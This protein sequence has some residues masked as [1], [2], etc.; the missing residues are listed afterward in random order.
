MLHIAICD[1]EPVEIRYLTA[2]VTQWAAVRGYTLRVSD[3]N[4]AEDFLFAYEDN[5]AMDILLLDIQMKAM[6][7]VA[8]A[9]RLRQLGNP[10]Q[11][12]FITGMP[13][14][15]AEGYDVSALHYLLKPVK[16][17]RLFGVLDKAVTLMHKADRTILLPRGGGQVR[18][19]AEDIW[20][21][22]VLSH[23]VSLCMT[24]GTA[25]TFPMRLSDMEA[26]LGEGFFKCHRSFIV[27]MAHVQRVTRT[28]MVLTGGKN[29]TYKD[30]PLSRGL[31][32][33]ANQ[34]FIHYN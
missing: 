1:D 34:A 20:Y 15:M 4:S 29:Q 25:Q 13:D 5:A 16:E 6:D 30:I 23:T 8:L 3:F 9:R 26:L 32:D 7:G 24:N 14:Y 21:A 10:A 22:E 19:K 12:V 28:A 2:L 18:I 33:A 31:Y 17:D 27:N 11:I